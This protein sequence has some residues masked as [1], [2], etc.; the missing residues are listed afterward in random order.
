MTENENEEPNSEL[1]D[2]EIKGRQRLFVL[3]YCTDESSLFNQSEAYK[4]AYTKKD[5]QTDKYIEPDN[6]TCQTNGSRLMKNEKIK[7]AIKRLL[8][9]TQADIDDEM[10][11]RILKEMALGATYNPADILDKNGKLVTKTLAQLGDKAKMI[12]QIEPTKF[13]IKY[14]LVNRSKYIDMLA[15]YLQLV[16]PETTV[17]I[18]LPV[19]EVTPKFTDDTEQSAVEKWNEAAETAT[20]E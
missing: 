12:A 3:Y 8:K 19:I 15:K 18:K 14:T 7:L 11:Y 1:W 2:S 16:K 4:K 20:K 17:D 6:T 13:G 9:V 10:V 5:K